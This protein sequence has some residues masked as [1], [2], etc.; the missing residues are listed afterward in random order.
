MLQVAGKDV[1]L[2]HADIKKANCKKSFSA[3]PVSVTIKNNSAATITNLPVFYQAEGQAVV[4][5]I[6]STSIAANDTLQYTFNTLFNTSTAGLFPIKVWAN[7]NGDKYPSNDSATTS[8][9]VMETIDNFPYYNDFENNSGPFLSEGTNNS[10]L[11]TTPNKYN[12]SYAAQDNKAW[13]TG[14]SNGYNF[15][16]NSYL[17]LGCLDFSSLSIDP[18][19][20]FN[21]ISLKGFLV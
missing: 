2:S 3:Q 9:V 13:T 6:I 17:Y 14:A 8:V 20:A 5:E 12:I 18:Y 4:S 11:W 19:I 16:E 1:A 7:N 21:F 15:N 10:W